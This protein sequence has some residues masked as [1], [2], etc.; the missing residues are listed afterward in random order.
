VVEFKGAKLV[1]RE[2]LGLMSINR[3]REY[4]A[5]RGRQKGDDFAEEFLSIVLSIQWY[6]R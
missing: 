1:D 2:A 6:I 5:Y 3:K 4:N